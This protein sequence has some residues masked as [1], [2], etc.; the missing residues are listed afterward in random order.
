MGK[1]HF[2]S[3]DLA[4]AGLAF[5]FAALLSIFVTA[6]V[7]AGS[8]GCAALLEAAKKGYRGDPAALRQCR[9]IQQSAEHAA[10]VG[11]HRG[12]REKGSHARTKPLRDAAGAAQIA[13][14]KATT[15]PYEAI[16]RYRRRTEAKELLGGA[17]DLMGHSG[18][19]NKGL[20]GYSRRKKH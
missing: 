8:S 19:K 4:T 6:P 1:L 5:G 2:V 10:S 12:K 15:H 3:P 16:Q 20:M 9:M 11:K 17:L 18:P 13:H 14:E 7:S